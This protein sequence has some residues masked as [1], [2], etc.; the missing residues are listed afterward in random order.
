MILEIIE[1]TLG[2]K[3]VLHHRTSGSKEINLKN[4]ARDG[5]QEALLYVEKY[6]NNFG[7]K[8]SNTHQQGFDF[9]FILVKE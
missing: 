6:I 1:F 5:F 7:F 4:R 3:R 9:T 8:I 2:N